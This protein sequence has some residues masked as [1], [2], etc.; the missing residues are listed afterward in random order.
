MEWVPVLSRLRERYDTVVRE[1]AKFG[2]V[3]AINTVLDFAVLNLLVFGLGVAPLRSKVAAALVATTSS[4]LMNRHWTFRHRDRQHVRRES[5]LFFL[6]NAIGLG[7]SLAVLGVVRYGLDLD[8][9]L[10]LNAANVVALAVGMVFRFWSYRRFVWLKPAEVVTAAED[11]DVV[12]A[13]VVDLAEEPPPE[14][15]ARA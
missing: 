5:T 7:I 10:A 9:P 4:Y 15:A 1:A 6:L 12:A 14:T 8:G 13:V 11:G 2:T 3:G